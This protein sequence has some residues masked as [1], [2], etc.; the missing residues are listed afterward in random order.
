MKRVILYDCERLVTRALAETPTGIERVDVRYFDHFMTDPDTTLIGVAQKGPGLITYRD[1]DLRRLHRLL[2]A[3]WLDKT[4]LPASGRNDLRA[5]VR[6]AWIS[7][8]LG[9]ARRQLTGNPFPAR[10]RQAATA[11]GDAPLLYVNVSHRGLKEPILFDALKTEL[12]VRC[13][14]YVHDLIPID[15]PQFSLPTHP[16]RHAARMRIVARYGDLI[17]TNSA[18]SADRLSAFVD[19]EGLPRPDPVILH[20]GVEPEFRQRAGSVE[21]TD[22]GGTPYFV[23]IGT[24]EPRKNHM[25]LLQVWDALRRSGGPVPQLRVIGRRGWVTGANAGY[26]ETV[27]KMAPDVVELQNLDDHALMAQL[28]G[29]QAL[30][31]PSFTEGWGMPLV[32]AMVAGVPVIASDI[33]A[34]REASQGR[35]TLI[36]PDDADGWRGAVSAFADPD[37]TARRGAIARMEGFEIPTWEDQFRQLEAALDAAVNRWREPDRSVTEGRLSSV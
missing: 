3:R 31:F 11:A 23:M 15:F 25:L 22:G 24:V 14:L 18:Y 2:T 36:D 20:I 7:K 33:P 32:E 21:M 26:A 9:K 4:D 27:E 8:E 16:E 29:A 1:R 35:A 30:L 17:L 6:R 10:I 37:G 5:I 34:F 28:K 19:R 13:V 12:G